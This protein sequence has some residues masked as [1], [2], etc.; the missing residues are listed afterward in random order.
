MTIEA[1][2]QI[3]CQ[4]VFLNRLKISMFYKLHENL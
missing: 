1:E 3:G 4:A 2:L